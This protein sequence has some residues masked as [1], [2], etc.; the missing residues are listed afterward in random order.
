MENQCPNWSTPELLEALCITNFTRPDIDH[1]INK[2]SRFMSNPNDVHWNILT[3]VLRYLKHTLEYTL[4]YTKY[5]AVLE[6]YSEDNWI[7]YT[8]YSKSTSG[9]VFSF[10]GGDVSWRSTK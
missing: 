3:R 6:K 2:L 1:V 7:F 5:P 8:K 9:Y 4:H 10:D